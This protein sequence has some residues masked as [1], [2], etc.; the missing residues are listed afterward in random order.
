MTKIVIHCHY[1]TYEW[2]YSE[3]KL[4][5]SLLGTP[6]IPSKDPWGFLD[7]VLTT[8]ALEDSSVS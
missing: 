4:F 1:V 6:W 8:T 3:N 7:A 2:N 5:P